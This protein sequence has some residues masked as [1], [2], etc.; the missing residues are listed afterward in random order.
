MRVRLLGAYHDGHIELLYPR[1]FGYQFRVTD[2][3]CGH[4]DWRYD[5]VRLSPCGH[6]VHEIE[7]YGRKEVGSWLVKASDV[8]FRWTPL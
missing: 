6:V 1:V 4:R 2:G 7:W 8:E 3:E 5:E